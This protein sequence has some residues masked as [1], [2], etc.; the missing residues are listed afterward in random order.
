MTKNSLDLS[1]KIEQSTI[2]L[3]KTVDSIAKNLEIKYLVV[4][5]TARDLVFHYGLGAVV[6]RATADI[7][8]GIQ[9]ES[10]QQ[11]K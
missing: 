2:E 10:W 4:G 11:F 7:D 5:A 8:F 1:G 9:V 3:F 6:K